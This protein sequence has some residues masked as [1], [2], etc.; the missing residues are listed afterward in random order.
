MF[1]FIKKLFIVA[2]TFFS[3]NPLNVSSLECVLINNHKCKIRRK[4]IDININELTS[5]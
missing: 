5:F 4:I 2:M 1:G 3:R